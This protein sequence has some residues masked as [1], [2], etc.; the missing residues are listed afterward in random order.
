MKV[1]DF[2]KKITEQE[3]LKRGVDIA[4]TAEVLKVVNNLL[5][6]QLYSLIKNHGNDAPS[7]SKTAKKQLSQK[8][9]LMAEHW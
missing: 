5:E 8:V 7:K 6:G 4:Q 9:N 1:T 3:G 2:A